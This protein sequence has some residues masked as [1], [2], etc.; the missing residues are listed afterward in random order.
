MLARGM[1]QAE[2]LQQMFGQKVED[3]GDKTD[4]EIEFDPEK[5]DMNP[6]LFEEF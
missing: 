1:S 3:T 5:F 6:V 2:I 4:E